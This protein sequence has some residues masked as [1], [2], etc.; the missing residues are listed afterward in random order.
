MVEA[1]RNIFKNLVVLKNMTLRTQELMAKQIIKKVCHPEEL[2]VKKGEPMKL[3]ILQKGEI[4]LCARFHQTMFSVTTDRIRI[5]DKS[6]PKL[7]SLGFIK[8]KNVVCDIKSLTYSIL[9][10]LSNEDLM[11][12]LKQS[13]MDYE[14]FCLM[15]DR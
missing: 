9:F 5:E 7:L 8:S 6:Q 12:I 4:G 10:Y 1:N 2:L 15:K 13:K 3:F 14:H 11:D